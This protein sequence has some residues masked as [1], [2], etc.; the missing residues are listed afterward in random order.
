MDAMSDLKIILWSFLTQIS[1]YFITT[2]NIYNIQKYQEFQ[3]LPCKICLYEYCLMTMIFNILNLIS[4]KYR[5]VSLRPHTQMVAVIYICHFCSIETKI[6]K[7]QKSKSSS[8]IAPSWIK[9]SSKLL[10]KVLYL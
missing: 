7:F 2:P 1:F 10:E 5:M 9:T 4:K 8:Q 6:S 3:H